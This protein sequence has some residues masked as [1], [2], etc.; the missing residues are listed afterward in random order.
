[1]ARTHLSVRVAKVRDIIKSG[2][3]GYRLKKG[4]TAT[5]WVR[6]VMKLQTKYFE[7]AR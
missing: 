3:F 4:V 5:Q 1:M 7:E 6:A 2:G